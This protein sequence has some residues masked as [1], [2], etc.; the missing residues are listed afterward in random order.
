MKTPQLVITNP[1]DPQN[2]QFV[3]ARDLLECLEAK[4]GE[5][6]LRQDRWEIIQQIISAREKQEQYERG[7]IGEILK[8][9]QARSERLTSTDPDTLIFLRDYS[10]GSRRRATNSDDNEP[11]TDGNVPSD[12]SE[13]VGDDG[14]MSSG[15]SSHPS[16]TDQENMDGTVPVRRTRSSG[17][18]ILFDVRRF[19][20]CRPRPSFNAGSTT[21]GGFPRVGPTFSPKPRMG[22]ESSMPH[23]NAMLPPGGMHQQATSGVFG[24]PEAYAGPG[25][26]VHAGHT[27]HPAL[28]LHVPTWTAMMPDMGPDPPPEMFGGPSVMTPHNMR[29]AFFENFEMPGSTHSALPPAM[30]SPMHYHNFVESS[31][32]ALP[33]RGGEPGQPTL[34]STQDVSIGMM[35]GHYY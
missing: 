12:G 32:R 15:S 4:R 22:M 29:H 6:G 20:T 5:P 11:E 35:A 27:G 7:E 26:M 23:D 30:I 19:A 17:D 31:R 9:G 28:N 10:D 33:F 14:D 1:P 3:N 25:E 2:Q 34:M 21:S 24:C 18:T 13:G 8:Y 16:P